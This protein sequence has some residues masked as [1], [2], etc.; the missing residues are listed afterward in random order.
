VMR[1]IVDWR[2]TRTPEVD[3]DPNSKERSAGTAA[4]WHLL[5]FTGVH[6]LFFIHDSLLIHEYD[7]EYGIFAFLPSQQRAEGAFRS[8]EHKSQ[9]FLRG[10]IYLK[11]V[12]TPSIFT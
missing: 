1:E 10:L 3:W 5:F 9:E 6:L 11:L 2:N 8:F 7:I 4:C 12:G